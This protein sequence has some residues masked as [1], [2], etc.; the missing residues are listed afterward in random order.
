[1]SRLN[2]ME[3]LSI[4][5]RCWGGSNGNSNGSDIIDVFVDPIHIRT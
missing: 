3:G 4:G 1:M 5:I 2:G